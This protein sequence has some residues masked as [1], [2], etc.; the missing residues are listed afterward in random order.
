MSLSALFWPIVGFYGHLVAALACALVAFWYGRGTAAPGKAR[1][2]VSFALGITAFWCVLVAATGPFSAIA[3]LSETARNLAWLWVVQAL[4]ASDGRDET[5]QLVRPVLVVLCVVETLQ[6]VLLIVASN[7]SAYPEVLA[8]TQQVSSL[9]RLLVAVG[10]LVLLHNLY[11]GAAPSTRSALRWPAV[12]LAALWAYDLNFY[13]IVH[14]VA[15]PPV[16]LAALR[17][18]FV[19]IV[20]IPLAIGATKAGSDRPFKPS[21]KVAFQTLSLMVIGAYLVSM[22]VIARGIATFDGDLARLTQ[23]GF[24]V[25]AALVALLWLPSSRMRKWLKVT[26]T[27]HLFQ[28]RYDYREEWLRFTRTI[29]RDDEMASLEE[30]VVQAIADITDS[31]RGLLVMP[32]EDAALSLA[33][34]WRWPG[35]AVPAEAFDTAAARFYEDSGFIV[36][37]DEVREGRSRHGEDAHVPAW[38]DELAPAWA[39]V[40]LNH[41]GRLIGLVVLAR[42]DGERNLDWEDLD[43]LRVVGQQSAS[44]LAE[45][46]GQ[47]ALLEASRFDEFNRRIAFVMHDIKNLASQLGLLARNAEKHADNP[48]FRADMLVT[49]RN[50]AD[51]LN[52]L[53]ARLG[54]YGQGGEAPL[55]PVSLGRVA[56]D[57]ARRFQSQH[58]VTFIAGGEVQVLAQAEALDQALTHLVQN[59][60]DASE[61]EAPVY[62][63]VSQSGLQGELEIVD[64]GSGMTADFIRRDLFQPFRSS[65]N[66]GFGIGAFEARELVRAMGGQLTVESQ[67]DL[68]TRFFVR[69]P[70]AATGSLSKKEVA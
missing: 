27:K 69:L 13:T 49:L 62:L 59:A 9:F 48:D 61:P 51:K 65:K 58:P 10:G 70:L 40:P 45:Q 44:Y 17:G 34:S 28:H 67:P 53:L 3:A 52:G 11:A 33:A 46:S 20:V 18:L 37:L 5:A 64:Q 68:G 16:E 35:V 4:F 43:L 41:Y 56:G 39:I 55:V 54:R 2:A 23:V 50:S 66:D 57:I 63:K 29:G 6:P 7:W 42:P 21:R 19:S 1:K 31:P 25:I 24:T 60:I 26:A 14:L 15:E 38:L 22:V 8:L 30:R 36:E 32:G 12:S 47:K